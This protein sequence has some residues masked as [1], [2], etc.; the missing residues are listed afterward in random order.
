MINFRTFA[1]GALAATLVAGPLPAQENA[2]LLTVTNGTDVA[3]EYF[4]F[5]TCGGGEWGKD[6]L[7]A[8]ETIK[9]GTRKVF[10]LKGGKNDCCYDLRV[11]LQ[12]IASR[13]KLN[14]DIC[15]ESEWVV[16]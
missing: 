15:R 1:I 11:K 10:S 3:I 4:Y 7:G 8:S 16:R 12:T 6:R 9:P 14:V 2:H 5:A 13:Q